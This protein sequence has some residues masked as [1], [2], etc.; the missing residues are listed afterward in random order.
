VDEHG[1]V[2]LDALED[3]L[4]EPAG[5]VAVQVANPEVGTRQPFEEAASLA[6]RLEVPVFTDAAAAVGRVPLP[7]G[8]AAAAASAHK[9]GGPA[10][11]GVLLVRKGTRWRAP[12]P[13]DDRLDPRQ[14]GFEN[15]PGVLAAAAALQAVAADREATTARQRDLV[16]LVRR[17]L[18]TIPDVSVVGHP[19]ERLP[20]VVTFSCLYVDGESLVTELDRRGFAVSS[21][22]ACTASTLEPSH[23]LVAMGA[24]THGN[25]RVSLG[26]ETMESDV[27]RFLDVLPGLV[28]ELSGGESAMAPSAPDGSAE[29][30][31]RGMGC[32]LPV[33]R[34]GNA[35]DELEVGATIAVVADDPA[36]RSDIA[37]WCRMAGHEL[38][39]EDTADDG[40][41]RFVVRRTH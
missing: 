18:A 21:G 7:D 41:P 28:K 25:V 35:V 22:S 15:V 27:R 3:A 40:V 4:R 31:C 2:R 11:V 9:W 36:A 5:A 23:V 20:H 1:R 29:L 24:L 19:T 32:P 26:R 34:L 17:E 14:A 8:W 10:G 12:F 13:T 16:D 38:V 33:I 37:A 39:G 6:A 30:D